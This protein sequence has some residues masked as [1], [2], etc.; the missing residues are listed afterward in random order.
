LVLTL[1][2]KEK[3]AVRQGVEGLLPEGDEE[4]K[5]LTTVPQYYAKLFST[6]RCVSS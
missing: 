4:G 2:T 5:F 6:Y 1:S 3:E